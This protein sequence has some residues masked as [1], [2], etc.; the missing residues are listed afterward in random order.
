MGRRIV[1]RSQSENRAWNSQRQ[2]KACQVLLIAMWW[3]YP[4]WATFGMS[5]YTQRCVSVWF[6]EVRYTCSTVPET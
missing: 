1:V 4:C 3:G 2:G 5:A 6:T